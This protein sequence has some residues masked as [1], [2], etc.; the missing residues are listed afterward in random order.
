MAGAGSGP[1]RKRSGS[2]LGGLIKLGFWVYVI[3][4]ILH[5]LPP[6]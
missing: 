1:V 5:G 3:A 4:A 2:F 6:G